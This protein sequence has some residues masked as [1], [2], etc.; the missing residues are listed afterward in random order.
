M[1]VSTIPT[2]L[3]EPQQHRQNNGIV[4]YRG[5]TTDATQTEL[6]IDGQP[7]RRLVHS[8][9]SSF[10]LLTL[11]IAHGPTAGGNTWHSEQRLLCRSGATGT[12]AISDLDN[13]TA[14]QQGVEV[15]GAVLG[16]A[17]AV[18][19]K[20]STLGTTGNYSISWTAVA[21]SGTTP[22]YMQLRVIGAAASTVDWEVK[23]EFL[24]VGAKG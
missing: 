4:F 17:G 24:E 2:S 8:T 19:P 13:T 18:T 21:A 1:R 20:A 22:A 15:A 11:A 7:N 23:V 12:I 14:G 10:I 6:F 16:N 5:R 3:R 9:D